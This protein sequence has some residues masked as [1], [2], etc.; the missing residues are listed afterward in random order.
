MV[1]RARLRRR[2]GV[3]QRGGQPGQGM[4]QAVLGTDRDLMRL[5]GTGPG[6]DGDL[7][8]GA[9]LVA[10]PPQPDLPGIEDPGG[11]AE[12]LLSLML[13]ADIPWAGRVWALPFLTVLAPSER[14]WQQQGRNPKLLSDWA[15]QLLLQGLDLTLEGGGGG[16]APWRPEE[17]RR[18]GLDRR[19][20]EAVS[21]RG[22][23]G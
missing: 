5:D 23:D 3:H 9:Q 13:L 16:H 4:E 10:D 11:G 21:F 7:A 6:V 18:D 1:V 20:R 15:R 19:R 14:Y 12:G 2:I 22:R 17:L 8:F